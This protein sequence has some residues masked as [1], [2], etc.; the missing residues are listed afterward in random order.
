MRILVGEAIV[1]LPAS[2][3]EHCLG[4]SVGY[5]WLTLVVLALL[6]LGIR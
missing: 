4:K 2:M 6:V 3:S 5:E 1:E